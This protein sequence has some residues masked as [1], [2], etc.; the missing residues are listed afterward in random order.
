MGELGLLFSFR[1]FVHDG[2]YL[3]IL[4]RFFHQGW[5][6]KGNLG[7]SYFAPTRNGGTTDDFGRRFRCYQQDRSNLLLDHSVT[8]YRKWYL[9]WRDR[10]GSVQAWIR[11]VSSSS[12]FWISI[13]LIP[14]HTFPCFSF[15]GKKLQFFGIYGRALYQTESFLTAYISLVQERNKYHNGETIAVVYEHTKRTQEM[16]FIDWAQ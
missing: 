7:F 8:R 9:R 1:A 13:F 14:L 16:L 4:V 15:W 11:V 6:C 10:S 12:C 3:A 2:Y 5:L